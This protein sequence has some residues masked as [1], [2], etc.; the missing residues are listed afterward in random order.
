M[1]TGKLTIDLDA[2]VAN[3]RALDRMSAET[4]RT[5]AVVKA[6][7]YGLGL[8]QVG[9]VLAQAG[10]RSFFVATAEEGVR[11]RRV[12]GDGPEISVFSGHMDGDTALIDQ[13]GLVPMLNSPEQLTR[14]FEALPGHPFGIQLDTGMN[15]LGMEKREWAAVAEVALSQRPRLVMSHLA[16]ADEPEH[17][18]NAV[19]LG[20]FIEMTEGINV[21]RSLSATGGTLMGPL[22]HFDMVR[23]GIGLYGGR[24]FEAARPV[25]RLRLP[26]IQT[27]LVKAGEIVGYSMTWTAKHDSII[28]T[29]SGGYADGL[30]RSMSNKATLFAGATPCPLVGRVSMDLLTIDIS[31]LTEVPDYLDILGTSQGVDDLADVSGTIGYELLTQLG[32]RYERTYTGGRA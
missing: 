18:L 14:H 5:G 25:L 27:R 10:A 17:E 32:G 30:I 19:Q 6:D 2:V 24:P 23:P 20:A 22:Y 28:A 1:G 8:G 12:L 11:L 29:V 31:H 4:V 26:V 13:A 3:W 9:R 16:C 7:G 21:P 15:R